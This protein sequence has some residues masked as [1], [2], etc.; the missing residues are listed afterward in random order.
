MYNQ[1]KIFSG[2]S[3]PDL[4]NEIAKHLNTELGQREIIKFSNEN[5]KVKITESVRGQDVFVVQTSCPPVSDNIMEML[6]MIHALRGAS[7][8][9][10][11]AVIPYFPYVRSDKKDEPRISITAKLMADLIKTAGADRVLTMDLHA[12]QIQGFFD[13][14]ADQLLA[15]PILCKYFIEKN[16][17]NIVVVAGDVGRAKLNI[18]YAE[19]L[20]APLAILEKRRDGDKEKAK[21]ANV[22]GNV[23]GKTAIMFDDEILTGG[24]LMELVK[25][26]KREGAVDIYAGIT[27]GILSKRAVPNIARSSLK[28]LVIT[29]T[30]PLPKE[31]QIDKIKVLSVAKLFAKAIENIHL[32]RPISTLFQTG[33]EEECS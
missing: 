33:G 8:D 31:K 28:E 7:A 12:A 9:R 5:I 26:L 15:L 30:V 21:V 27:H 29:N 4:A 25:A 10:I 14:P 3:N 20:K 1:L 18:K 2:N 17:Q 32:G 22:I 16:L 23:K 6:I 13:M 11:T 19:R 24:S